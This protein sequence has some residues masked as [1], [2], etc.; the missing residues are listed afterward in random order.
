MS[1]KLFYIE[2]HYLLKIKNIFGYRGF[3]HYHALFYDIKNNVN[4]KVDI[5]CFRIKRN[6]NM[7]ILVMYWIFLQGMFIA[8]LW[9][10]IFCL[11][12]F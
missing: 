1:K 5:M 11:V 7:Y 2:P 12:P 6:R 3:C 10:E 9:K 8:S 4:N